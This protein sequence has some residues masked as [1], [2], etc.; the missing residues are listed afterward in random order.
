MSSKA[1]RSVSA[2]CS[3]PAVGE[4]L[5]VVRVSS[6]TSSRSSSRF[7]VWLSADCDVP[8]RAAA[9]V[10]LRSSQTVRNARR[11]PSSSRFIDESPA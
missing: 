11:S 3:P 5:R 4:T 6:R 2:S 1:G 10:K 8:S 9:R 7:T